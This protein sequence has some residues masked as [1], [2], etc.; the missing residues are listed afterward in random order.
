MLAPT[1]GNV[2]GR[3][4]NV[5]LSNVGQ[6]SKLGRYP[7]HFHMAGNVRGSYIRNNVI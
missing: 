1:E 4:E 5:E 6:A 2:V 3:I 7:I